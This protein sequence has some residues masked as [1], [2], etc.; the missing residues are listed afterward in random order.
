MGLT[1]LFLH[2]KFF[3]VYGTFWESC[4]A[5]KIFSHIF[6]SDHVIYRCKFLVALHPGRY[7]EIAQRVIQGV[8][9]TC[10]NMLEIL[11]LLKIGINFASN[12]MWY[13]SATWYNSVTSSSREITWWTKIYP[14]TREYS[15]ASFLDQKS[16]ANCWFWFF[17]FYEKFWFGNVILILK[18]ISD[19]FF[20]I[21]RLKHWMQFI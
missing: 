19:G 14:E 17:G 20:I 10:W 11:R 6:G 15:G 5:T 8:K 18:R 16:A 2:R 12:Y 4:E 21:Q 13:L 1:I 3:V 9:V 7:L